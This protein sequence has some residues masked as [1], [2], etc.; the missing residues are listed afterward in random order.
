M[1]NSP[2]PVVS[3]SK[4]PPKGIAGR[5]GWRMTAGGANAADLVTFAKANNE[6]SSR[7]SVTA[8]SAGIRPMRK[9][10]W[11]SLFIRQ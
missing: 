3:L 2:L 6:Q 8:R 1:P 11:E 7:G 4:V 10:S 5:R 9:R